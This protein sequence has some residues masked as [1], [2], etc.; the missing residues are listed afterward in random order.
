MRESRRK[1][2]SASRDAKK[3]NTKG[4]ISGCDKQTHGEKG[5]GDEERKDGRGSRRAEKLTEYSGVT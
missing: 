5:E 3:R 2:E 4:A 1:R